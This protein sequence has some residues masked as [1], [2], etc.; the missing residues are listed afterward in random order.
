MEVSTSADPAKFYWMRY[1]GV[2][3]R[4]V[5]SEKGI[6]VSI[7]QRSLFGVRELRGKEVDEILLEDGTKFQLTISKSESLM[8]ASKPFT[9]KTP[10]FSK[11]VKTTPAVAKKTPVNRKPSATK[12]KAIPIT[13]LGAMLKAKAPKVKVVANKDPRKAT[14][15][16]MTGVP[17]KIDLPRT[18]KVRLSDLHLPEV[19]DFADTE[20]PE[21][22]RRYQIVES[23]GVKVEKININLVDP[24]L[25]NDVPAADTPPSTTEE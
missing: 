22:F 13:Q 19:E 24:E 2:K 9:G 3:A 7:P 17:S 12:P 25:G 21:E 20:L 6:K 11:K 5:T 4:T 10:D 1:T 23:T 15:T 18:V 14:V 16:Q 8:N